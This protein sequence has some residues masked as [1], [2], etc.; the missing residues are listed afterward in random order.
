MARERIRV[1][2]LDGDSRQALPVSKAL[3][4][5][6]HYV[7]V[8]CDSRVSYGSW[9]RYP[10][11]REFGPSCIHEP[12]AYLGFLLRLLRRHS[13]DVTIPLFDHTA[14][15][16][17]R[18]KP[19]LSR[20][21]HVPIPDYDIFMLARDKSKT[22][23]I[24]KKIGVP[25][26]ATYDPRQDP[27]EH[28]A[29][30]VNFPCLVKPNIGHGAIGLRR[31]ETPEALPQ[32]YHE[33]SREYGPC[34]IQE[35]IPQTGMQ[36][37][38][39]IFRGREGQIHA[40]VV[41]NKMR[42]FPVTGGTSSLNAT[43]DRPDIVADCRRLLDTM[44]WES[45]ADVDL[46]EDPRDGR[47]KVM[48]IN[49]RITGSI[50]IAF[51]AGVDF[52][53]LLVRHALGRELPTFDHYRVGIYLRYM[54][55]D[56]LWFLHSPDRWRARPS[57]FRFLGPDLCYQEGSWEDPMPAV[58]GFLSGLAKYLNPKFREGKLGKKKRAPQESHG[59]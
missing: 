25:H 24:C 22:M 47:V 9:S 48:E 34:M 49:P 43:V 27:L 3:R 39:Q 40:A 32:I 33:T 14:T 59:L 57:W 18:H 13:Y 35:F 11:H 16:A 17:S 21:T 12:E 5:A 10:H 4:Q 46:I 7:T 29:A 37:K 20:Y 42:Y 15:L 19:E 52:A 26:P 31:V 23:Q 50:K 38:T 36:Y 45:H 55:L 30:Q 58:A 8:L 28:I 41:F 51:E 53:D 44:N 6:G 54:P 2:L 1:L 56:I